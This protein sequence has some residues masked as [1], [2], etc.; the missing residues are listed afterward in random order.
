M[1]D[2]DGQT[3]GIVGLGNMGKGMARNL[4]KA[5]AQVFVFNR[6]PAAMAIMAN[7]NMTPCQSGAAL[8]RSVGAGPIV[9]MV[10]DTP[11]VE[12]AL[13][14][15]EGVAA[16]LQPGALVIDMG[17]TAVLATRKFAQR[18]R[19]AGG[20]YVD[21]PVS[22]GQIGADA[23]TLSIM[24]GGAP[25]SFSRALPLFRAMGK[26]ITHVGDVGAGQVAKAANQAIVGLTIAA[27]SEALALAEAAGVDPA[28]VRQA[29]LGGFAASRILEVHGQRMIDNAFAPGGRVR[30][31]R[32]D[33]MQA[34]ELAQACGL[35]LPNLALN[36]EQ[37]DAMIG[38][39]DGDL[40]HSSLIRLYR[41]SRQP[42]KP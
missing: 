40:D 32:K 31:Q 35:E 6:S 8:A 10:T 39:G 11:S 14:G 27:V 16:G 21:A 22:G 5:G 3:V 1:S 20:E 7:E 42:N 26:T 9:L 12:V 17:T 19:Q 41:A 30:V 15:D 34:L 33:V 2:L 4:A 37:W 38:R 18:I 24:A 29:L 36:L 13:F 25:E 23:G 28:K